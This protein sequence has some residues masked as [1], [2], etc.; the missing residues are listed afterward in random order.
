M[1]PFGPALVRGLFLLLAAAPNASLSEAKAAFQSLD[2]A[3]CIRRLEPAGGQ[4][5]PADLAQV[6]L[7]RGLCHYQ[8]GD[9]Q[10]AAEHFQSALQLEPSTVPP[11][12]AN[13]RAQA[14][15]TSVAAKVKP[16]VGTPRPRSPPSDAPKRVALM[17]SPLAPVAAAPL[18]GAVLPVVLGS[19]AVGL[20][21]ATIVFGLNAKAD[22]T[23]ANDNNAFQAAAQKS[24][25]LAEREALIANVGLAVASAAAV[26]AVVALLLQK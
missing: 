17:P 21:A 24:G 2:Y 10:D 22:E 20:A 16:R 8:L 3:T 7:Y 18:P 25:R 13:R 9:E 5:A 12:G 6:E 4:S 15:F 11:P 14:F 19:A 1:N 26:G 23:R